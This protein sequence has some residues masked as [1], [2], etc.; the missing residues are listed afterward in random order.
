M[1]KRCIIALIVIII[2]IFTWFIYFNLISNKGLS[3]IQKEIGD[4]VL[5]DTYKFK[6]IN[7]EEVQSISSYYGSNAD[8]A[9]NNKFV[10]IALQLTN[11][12]NTAFNFS[13]ELIIIDD[14]DREYN[15]YYN[16]TDNINN[17]INNRKLLPGITEAGYLVYEL[18]KD[19]VSYNICLWHEAKKEL[20]TIK[21]K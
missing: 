15:S 19:S 11:I 8:A 18:P 21:L 4:E 1:R 3:V 5:T 14:K 12:T 6:V 2:A 20:N 10:I 17:Y 9:D 16:T 7:V 13:P